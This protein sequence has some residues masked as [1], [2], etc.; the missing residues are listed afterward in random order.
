M[1][2]KSLAELAASRGL[3]KT[4]ALLSG[5][6]AGRMIDQVADAD[7]GLTA[8]IQPDPTLKL[9]LMTRRGL[10]PE[11]TMGWIETLESSLERGLA[12]W[13]VL[14]GSLVIDCDLLGALRSS[15]EPVRNLLPPPGRRGVELRGRDL[16][17]VLRE[18]L[19]DGLAPPSEAAMAAI[20]LSGVWALYAAGGDKRRA[21]EDPEARSGVRAQGRLLDLAHLPTLSSLWLQ[22]VARA[23]GDDEAY[24]ELVEA[25]LD[26][27]SID[28]LPSSG[29]GL[30]GSRWAKY[31]MARAAIDRGDAASAYALLKTIDVL[32][33]APVLRKNEEAGIQLVRTELGL[34][35]G[36]RPVPPARIEEIVQTHPTWRYAARVRACMAAA[37]CAPDSSSPLRM[38]DE[39]LTTFGND[40]AIWIGLT[41][42]GPSGAAWYAPMMARLAREATFLP[43]EPSVW[44]A[45][46]TFIGGGD[47]SPALTE[48]RTRLDEQTQL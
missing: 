28:H 44:T 26:A 10:Q 39:Y 34:R 17:D 21:V 33:L 8:E 46:A 27:H 48:I 20:G 6:D 25:L 19:G 14:A 5:A 11:L 18:Q 36:E 23:L 45:I 41:D 16:F 1:S 15:L 22:L 2:A 43:H 38:L 9:G 24:G 12:A 35:T 31:A 29:A 40:D 42:F 13:D 37:I 32:T 3:T 30:S 7:E 47:D 4:A